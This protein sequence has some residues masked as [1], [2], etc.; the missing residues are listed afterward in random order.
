MFL[1][2]NVHLA[3]AG[4]NKE[5]RLPI[6]DVDKEESAIRRAFDAS[7]LLVGAH[8]NWAEVRRELRMADLFHFIADYSCRAQSICARHPPDRAVA[9]AHVPHLG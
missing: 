1:I 4:K 3:G 2:Q 7:K 6:A 8:A 9:P 5:G